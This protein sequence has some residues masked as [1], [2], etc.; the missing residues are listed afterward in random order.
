[1]LGAAP[2]DEQWLMYEWPKEEP[3]PTK[4]WLSTLHADTP[5]K[6]LI[7]LAK[8]RWRVERD[9]QDLKQEAGL[10]HLEGRSWPGFHHHA[11]LCAVAHAFLALRRALSLPEPNT[12]D[13][14]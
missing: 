14:A 8:L 5:M 1:M 4:F 2:G 13:A 6:R 3:E 9:Y 10:D 12:V 7:H 11:A